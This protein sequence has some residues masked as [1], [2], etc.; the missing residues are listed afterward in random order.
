[1]N[2]T[3][4]A[5]LFLATLTPLHAEPT[6]ASFPV[7]ASNTL[8]TSDRILAWAFKTK[9]SGFMVKLKGTV[10]WKLPDDTAGSRHQRFIVRL[11]SRQTLLI[12]HNIDLAPRVSALKTNNPV[13]IYG[14]YI[15]NAQGG[16]IHQTHRPP[17]ASKGGGWIR[18]QGAI[19][20]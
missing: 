18:Y 10:I 2:L 11:N 13:T 19:Y 1:M 15:W 5:C 9:T 6:C 8:S 7:T 16:I 3:L 14:E 20:Q 12:A 4:L 17:D